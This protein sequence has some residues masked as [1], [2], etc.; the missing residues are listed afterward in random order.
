[1]P[2][3][4]LPVS[5]TQE[6][7]LPGHKIFHENLLADQ[8]LNLRDWKV[9]VSLFT[10]LSSTRSDKLAWPSPDTISGETKLQ[11]NIVHQTLKKLREYGWITQIEAECGKKY[12]RKYRLNY[13]EIGH[14][15]LPKLDEE[16]SHE[17]L[18]DESQ[19]VTDLV[20]K[21]D[22]ISHESL[23][24]LHIRNELINR[25]NEGTNEREPTRARED[26]T[27]SSQEFEMTPISELYKS[28]ER[29]HK[30]PTNELHDETIAY[31]NKQSGKSFQESSNLRERIREGWK[32]ED[33]FKAVDNSLPMMND[34]FMQNYHEPDHIFQKSKIE[35]YM[36]IKFKPGK[37]KDL[38]RE[39]ARESMRKFIQKEKQNDERRQNH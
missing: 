21:R 6:K 24:T 4:S 12:K 13:E 11:K 7:K 15:S 39:E 25:T 23:P 29:W 37:K 34:D 18:P 17:S 10:H 33:L 16:I 38:T 8:R 35:R 32:K 27:P 5:N 3:N 20:T 9:L 1:M 14:E 22:Q 2:H 28:R 19:N 30:A 36:N 31:F 26:S